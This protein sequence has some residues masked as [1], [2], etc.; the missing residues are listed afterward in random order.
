MNTQHILYLHGFNS[1]SQSAKAVQTQDYVAKYHQQVH[2]HC[3]QL[4]S[5]PKA[6]IAQLEE[7]INSAQAEQWYVM[8]SSLGGYFASYLAEKYHLQAVLINPAVRPY[9][10]LADY[11]GQQ[12]NPYTGEV[13][14]VTKQ[15]MKD[16]QTLDNEKISK[17][18]YMVMVQ[19]G[20]EVLDYQQAVEKYQGSEIII[21]QG[22]DHSFV[23]YE[24][25][26][27]QIMA[28]FELQP[29]NK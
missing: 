10:L 6:V 24:E 1:S 11:I 25:M 5:S 15:D 27:P 2:F 8:G 18:R 4:L 12:Q 22:G 19:T 20:D 26:L 9:E 3:P 17:N 16:L 7:I 13:Y 29:Q 28:F 23:N 14:Q 21:Q